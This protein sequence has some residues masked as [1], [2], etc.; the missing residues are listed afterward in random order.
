MTRTGTYFS[1]D[2]GKMFLS[3][4]TYKGF[5]ISV[6]SHVHA[7]QFLLGEGCEYVPSERFVQHV[8]EEYFGHQQAK[9]GGSDNSTAQQ[10]GYN[11]L[12]IAAPRDIAPVLT[13]NVGGCYGK[14]KCHKVSEEPVKKCKKIAKRK[15]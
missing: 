12:T 11:N 7:I 6:F 5:K 3:I 8:I 1:D 2:R 15:H 9:E 10:F 13:G 14:Q 4:Q